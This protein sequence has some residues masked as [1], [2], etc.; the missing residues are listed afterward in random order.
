[1]QVYQLPSL[2][3]S[4]EIRIGRRYHVA[5][6][7]FAG[8][9]LLRTRS[10]TYQMAAA[11]TVDQTSTYGA[12][13]PAP[14][15]S[16]SGA[17]NGKMTSVMSIAFA[18]KIVITI[19]QAGKLAH[20][21][22]VPLSSASADPMNPGPVSSGTAENSLLPM[23]HLTATTVLGGTKREDEIIGQTLA[24]TIASAILMKRPS[25]E[26]LLVVGLGLEDAAGSMN[27]RAQFEEA[28]GLVLEVL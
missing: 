7:T 20:W 1:L 13:F 18:D 2:L 5:I 23:S 4:R 27:A 10:G 15:K 19:S 16:S 6:N 3:P 11:D 8:S 24:S 17:I 14:S 26:R 9:K 12:P 25:E 21:V 28:V 22:H